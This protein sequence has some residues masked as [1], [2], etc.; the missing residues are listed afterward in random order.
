MLATWARLAGLTLLAP[1]SFFH[2]G[3]LETSNNFAVADNF[4][5]ETELSFDDSFSHF[6]CHFHFS[7]L[8]VAFYIYIV[9]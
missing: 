7:F 4:D 2:R 6:E 1:A 3:T 5:S 9:H 8:V